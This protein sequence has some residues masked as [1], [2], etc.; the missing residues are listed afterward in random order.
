[1]C[2]CK[3]VS[4]TVCTCVY[5]DACTFVHGGQK[6]ASHPSGLEMQVSWDMQPV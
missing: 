3:Q 4:V 1:M 5:S 2:Q 6:G